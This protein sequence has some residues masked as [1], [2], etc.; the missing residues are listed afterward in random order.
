MG[1]DSKIEWTDHTW[2]PWVGCT[3]VAPACDHCYAEGWSKRSG[4]VEWGGDR[5]RTS[6]QNWKQPLKWNRDAQAAGKPATVFCLSL[7][8]IWDNQIDPAWRRDAFAVMRDTP[9][10]VYLLLSK[11]IGNAVKMCP[12]GLPRNAVIGATMVNQEE[13]D[14]DA[15]KLSDAQARLSAVLSF[16]SIEPMLGPMNIRQHMPDWIIC[17]GESGPGA[18][19]MEEGWAAS[20][21]R[22][23]VVAGVPF[24]M[25]QMARKAPIPD[26]LA[27]R[28]F[29]NFR[30]IALPL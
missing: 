5:R 2:N 15:P 18:R 14:R 28:E 16:A 11:R 13:W 7:G 29:P 3:K 19:H 24:F 21:M 6:A 20:I 25:K 12:D 27:L 30:Q 9:W 8:D 1:Q 4:L 10:L 26:F 17:G 23:A 22:Q